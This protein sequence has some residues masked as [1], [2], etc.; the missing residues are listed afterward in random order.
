MS[1]TTTGT[2]SDFY[3]GESKRFTVTI[4]LNGTVQDIR[5]DTVTLRI[6][7]RRADADSVALLSKAADVTTQGA[8]G[9]AIFDLDTSDTNLPPGR[10]PLDVEWVLSGGAEYILYDSAITVKERV[11][12][13]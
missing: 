1:A 8:S 11:S 13:A 6:K 9:V 4:T 7:R 5:S 10:Y 3:P 2:I 12:D